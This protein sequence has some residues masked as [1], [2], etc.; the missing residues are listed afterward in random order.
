VI[1]HLEMDPNHR[2]EDCGRPYCRVT[3]AVGDRQ[4]GAARDSHLWAIGKGDH[5][6]SQ[7]TACAEDLDAQQL[8][9]AVEVGD[10][11]SL[12]HHYVNH[13]CLSHL[14]WR[15]GIDYIDK[16]CVCLRVVRS[17]IRASF[18]VPDFGAAAR[19]VTVRY[20][21]V[22]AS[23][24]PAT[25]SSARRNTSSAWSAKSGPPEAS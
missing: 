6:R 4:A 18:R 12:A 1:I 14:P 9:R 11:G 16:G 2:A 15:D 24:H 13:L 8:R 17:R 21:H 7:G 22:C 3:D 5:F 19:R 23:C 20:S 10:H 25:A